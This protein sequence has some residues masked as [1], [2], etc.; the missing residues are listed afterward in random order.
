MGLGYKFGDNTFILNDH[1]LK[2]I[3]FKY[4]FKATG[5]ISAFLLNEE[6]DSISDLDDFSDILST[7]GYTALGSAA[8]EL[9]TLA[10]AEGIYDINLNNFMKSDHFETLYKRWYKELYEIDSIKD[11]LESDYLEKKE[12]RQLRKDSRGRVVGGGFGVSGAVK[13]MVTA[14]AINSVTGISHSIFNGIGN[15]IDSVQL[16]MKKGELL[17]TVK[18]NRVLED[19]LSDL[20]SGMW[21]IL[22]C[23][24]L[25]WHDT[26][27]FPKQGDIEKTN[28]IIENIKNNIIPD[29]QLDIVLNDIL[30]MNPT[31]E[32]LYD[33][34][35]ISRFSD[36]SAQSL[37]ILGYNLGYLS[38]PFD[39][40]IE[41]FDKG[42][43]EELHAQQVFNVITG[44]DLNPVSQFMLGKLYEKAG[45]NQEAE[46]CFDIAIQQ[47][48]IEAEAYLIYKQYDEV[49][50]EDVIIKALKGE[51]SD[52][53]N[54]AKLLLDN[55]KSQESFKWI[56]DII[57][58]AENEQVVQAL[59]LLTS[60]N[61]DG[62]TLKDIGELVDRIEGEFKQDANLFRGR[63]FSFQKQYEQAI[64]AYL[65]ADSGQ[66]FWEL[67]DIYL[68]KDTFDFVKYIYIM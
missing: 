35:V 41:L 65:A 19:L 62:K 40:M 68:K 18:S 53:L 45:M 5:Y 20:I 24:I 54:L 11:D 6:L 59:Y 44:V 58:T 13:G 52:K 2:V 49:I 15:A 29:G 16:S 55:D 14:S 46:H 51:N 61:S 36:E 1:D 28:A 47:G 34:A 26:K 9:I 33:E 48:C 38:H 27:F 23:D 57:N 50:Q 64:D 17:S 25:R 60:V 43:I 37:R 66:A 56:F 42:A 22:V 4:H 8:K 12:Y 3:Y 31:N 7:Y 63:I 21:H 10:N 32:N 30:A 39:K 67:A